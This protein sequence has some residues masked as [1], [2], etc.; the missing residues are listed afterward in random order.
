[1]SLT[2]IRS[3]RSAYEAKLGRRAAEEPTWM[4]V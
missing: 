1:M 2:Q 4:R 3:V